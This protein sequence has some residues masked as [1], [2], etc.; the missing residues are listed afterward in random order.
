MRQ[1]EDIDFLARF[2]GVLQ[3][4]MTEY[5]QIWIRRCGRYAKANLVFAPREWSSVAQ[6]APQVFIDC[7]LGK[8]VAIGDASDLLCEDDRG[9]NLARANQ[10]RSDK[11]SHAAAMGLNWV[12]PY[13]YIVISTDLLL[14]RSSEHQ[15]CLASKVQ[16]DRIPAEFALMY[17]KGVSKLR[18]HLK[19]LNQVIT[20]SFLRK[21]KRFSIGDAIRNRGVTCCRYVV[22]V[23]FSGMKAWKF[24][25]GVVPSE[26]KYLL[27]EVWWWA[28]GF[29]NLT[30]RVLKQPAESAEV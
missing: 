8:V 4:R 28:A 20:P 2:F 24:L 14:G 19:H 27:N 29:H 6:L 17:D 21:Q 5:T 15:A 30:T 13:G 1:R 12:T 16:L 25:A 26:D 18:V 9:T 7:G 23:P 3:Q 11:S 22:E 10:S